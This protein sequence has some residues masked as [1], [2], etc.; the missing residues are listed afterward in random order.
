MYEAMCLG[1]DQGSLRQI[2][3]FSLMSGYSVKCF[4]QVLP[5]LSYLNASHLDLNDSY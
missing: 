2:V 1:V 4:G 3:N 5:Y